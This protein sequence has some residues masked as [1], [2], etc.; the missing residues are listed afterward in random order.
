[1][2]PA[3]SIETSP[4]VAPAP[5]PAPRASW[6]PYVAP[7][8]T[9]LVATSLEDYLPKA[10]GGPDPTWYPIAYAIKVAVV[11]AVVVACRSTWRDLRPWPSAGSVG[12]AVG[13]GLAV[14]AAWVGLD[15]LYPVPTWFGGG[16]RASFDPNVLPT[17]AR[18]GFLAVRLYGLVLLV[19]FF[20]E[21]FWRSFAIR[22]VIDPEFTRVPIGR[23]TPMAAGITAA[24]FAMAH[25]AEW[26]PALL[27]G[28]AWAWLLHRTRS[29]TACVISH[30]VANL[31]LGGYILATGAWKFW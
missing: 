27:T 28:L 17:A 12:L 23:V 18:L 31:G 30:A 1:M 11:T 2:T 16:K 9:F 4:P 13:I 7:M 25:P 3:E 5:S 14:A 22:Y 21:V 6:L 20:E 8:A 15:G 29:L 10:E 24:V 19:P 26:L